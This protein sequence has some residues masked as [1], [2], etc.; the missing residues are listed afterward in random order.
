MEA[1]PVAI[2][3]PGLSKSDR[4]EMVQYLGA[5]NVRFEEETIPSGVHGEIALGTAIIVVS[6]I[7]LRGFI[8]YLIYR[9]HGETFDEEIVVEYPDKTRVIKRIRYQK[10][11]EP[12]DKKIAA[13][14]SSVDLKL[15]SLINPSSN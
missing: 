13:E 4:L 5:E 7:A 2:R 15:G 12:A 11:D 14:L 1:S 8:A 9:H 6:A 3:L 10:T